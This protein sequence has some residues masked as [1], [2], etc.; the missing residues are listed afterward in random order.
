[1]LPRARAGQRTHGN[2]ALRELARLKG[3]VAE[4]DAAQGG[5]RVGVGSLAARK[6]RH[7]AFVPLHLA[8]P[9]AEAGQ[10]GGHRRHAMGGALLRRIAPRLVPRGEDPEIAGREHF[11]VFHIQEAVPPVEQG[12]NKDHL[13]VVFRTVV[14]PETLAGVEDGVLRLVVDVVAADPVGALIRGPGR[15]TAHGVGVHAAVPAHDRTQREDVGLGLAQGLVDARQRFQK[16]VDTLVVVFIASGNDEN[17]RVRGQFAAQ[18]PFRRVQNLRPEALG[19]RTVL[20]VVGDD[21]HVEAVGRD[22]VGRAAQKHRGLV[23]RDPADRGEAVGFP[24]R[25]GFHRALGRDVVR[26]RLVLR[27]DLRHLLVDVEARSGH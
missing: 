11:L 1:M 3:G 7:A 5:N 6:D 20:G 19:N 23:R 21:A 15:I 14:Q 4:K 8:H 17:P 18:E 24:R 26:A 9:E 25:G 22:H 27:V 2:P 12:R 13:H 10:V 16:N